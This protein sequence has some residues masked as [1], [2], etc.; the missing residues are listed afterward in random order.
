MRIAYCVLQKKSQN[1]TQWIAI[2]KAI[3][4]KV[5]GLPIHVSSNSVS[6][7]FLEVTDMHVSAEKSAST[8]GSQMVEVDTIDNLIDDYSGKNDRVFLKIDVQG[9]EKNVIAGALNSLDRIGGF[10]V[11]ISLVPMYKNEALFGEMLNVMNELGYK[12]ASIEPGFSNYDTGH[13]LQVDGV[14]LRE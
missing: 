4:D 10:Q 6:S 13:L 5:G 9:F 11:E 14:F 3:G 8:I 2:N 12:L 7:S 1:D